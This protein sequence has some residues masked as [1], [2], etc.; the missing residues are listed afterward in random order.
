[1]LILSRLDEVF[2][3]N[4]LCN[5]IL[6]QDLLL[7]TFDSFENHPFELILVPL[8]IALGFLNCAQ[9]ILLAHA[10]LQFLVQHGIEN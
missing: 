7:V 3:K 4:T 6:L 9:N 5:L 1:M 10:L 8:Q 2:L